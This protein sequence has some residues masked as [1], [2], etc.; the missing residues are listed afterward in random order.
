MIIGISGKINSGKDLIGEIILYLTDKYY[1]SKVGQEASFENWKT[2]NIHSSGYNISHKAM[3]EVNNTNHF[4]IKKFADKLKDIVCI[5]LGCTIEQLEN[6]EFKEQE[7]GE[8]WWKIKSTMIHNDKFKTKDVI[9]YDY[10]YLSFLNNTITNLDKTQ[11]I[12]MNIEVIKTTPRLLLQLLGTKCGR[13]II[14]PNI[15][16]I[17]TFSNYMINKVD[18]DF[19]NMTLEDAKS[20]GLIE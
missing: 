5:L 13:N 18:E 15:W 1:H 11:F 3:Y 7:L 16:C 12:S 2:S 8:E 17:S 20:F 19:L 4:V 10:K 9:F 14:H 6:R